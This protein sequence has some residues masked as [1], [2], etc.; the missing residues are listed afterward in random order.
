MT[1]GDC[2]RV[3][4]KKELTKHLLRYIFWQINFLEREYT[5]IEDVE[6]DAVKTIYIRAY[7]LGSL[8]PGV[9]TL[10]LR[11]TERVEMR[12]DCKMK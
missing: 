10:H 4:G 6:I 1:E 12:K 11:L 5:E 9:C 8:C 2:E 7:S 3:N